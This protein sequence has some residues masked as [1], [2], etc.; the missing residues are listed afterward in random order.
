M[1]N[2][3]NRLLDLPNHTLQHIVNA[4][5][6]I[7]LLL[8]CGVQ[9]LVVL[10]TLSLI[11][12]TI[13]NFMAQFWHHLRLVCGLTRTGACVRGSVCNC[14]N[15]IAL[16]SRFLGE[17]LVNQPASELSRTHSYRRCSVR[18]FGTR[19]HCGSTCSCLS[20][21]NPCVPT[22]ARSKKW[23]CSTGGCAST[24][25][26]SP[27]PISPGLCLSRRALEQICK[28]LGVRQHTAI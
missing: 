7:A 21:C 24:N 27:F 23:K 6:H 2:A 8:G 20:G 15:T 12:G 25:S 5:A 4:L 28:R 19:I 14:I 17:T 11:E 10:W 3:I 9:T 22:A 26:A 13:G 16:L 1:D 18:T